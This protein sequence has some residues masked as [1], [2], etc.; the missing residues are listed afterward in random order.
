MDW[1]PAVLEAAQLLVLLF[2]PRGTVQATARCL[3]SRKPPLL[4]IKHE[5]LQQQCCPQVLSNGVRPIAMF[6]GIKAAVTIQSVE[7]EVKVT[8]EHVGGL[9]I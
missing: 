5:G 1:E 7:K 6:G 9:T 8:E 2:A 3:L 4:T